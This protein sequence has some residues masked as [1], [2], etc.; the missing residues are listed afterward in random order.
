[1]TYIVNKFTTFIDFFPGTST[2][3]GLATTETTTVA[4]ADRWNPAAACAAQ[5]T[6]LPA[7]EKENT[8]EATDTETE[9]FTDAD[10][11]EINFSKQQKFQ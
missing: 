2:A 8:A 9:T 10:K 5:R 7:E 1:M 11:K 3:A 6:T 4:V